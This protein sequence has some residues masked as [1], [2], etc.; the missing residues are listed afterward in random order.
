VDEC[1][2]LAAGNHFVVCD[3]RAASDAHDNGL[4]T[5]STTCHQITSGYSLSNGRDES[6]MPANGFHQRHPPSEC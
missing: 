6:I 4:I 2:P 5:T 3:P 1:K